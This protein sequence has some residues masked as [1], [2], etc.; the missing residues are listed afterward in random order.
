MK[1]RRKRK[2]RVEWGLLLISIGVMFLGACK[3]DF[4][5]KIQKHDPDDT[6]SV[7]LK[8]PKVLY[9]IVDGLRGQIIPQINPPTLTEMTQDAV[10]AYNG[11]SNNNHTDLSTWADM[12]TGVEPNKH[13]VRGADI[14]GN[15]LSDYPMFFKRLKE[16][17]PDYQ[18]AAFCSS[19][20]LSDDLIMDADTNESFS[21]NDTETK[22]A[23][24]KELGKENVTAILGEFHEVQQAGEDY[25]YDSSKKEYVDAIMEFDQEVDEIISMLKQRKN[26]KKENWLVIIA[27][28]EG[29]PATIPAED[30]DGTR[31]SDP[32]LNTFAIIYNPRFGSKFIPK[33]N[34]ANLPYE[35]YAV[36]LSGKGKSATDYGDAVN[37]YVPDV[38]QYNFGTSG[39][40]TVQI[41]VKVEDF[42]SSWP[43]FFGKRKSSYNRSENGWMFMFHGDNQWRVKV[44]G[45]KTTGIQNISADEWHTLTMKIYEENSKRLVAIYTDGDRLGSTVDI[46]GDDLSNDL[47]LTAGW[48]DGWTSTQSELYI[49]DIKMYDT[50]LADTYIDEHGGDI[51]LDENSPYYHNVIG[52]W[53]ATDGIGDKF[54]DQSPYHNDMIFNVTDNNEDDFVWDKFSVLSGL[55]HVPLPSNIINRVP[56]GVDMPLIIYKWMGLKINT[57]DLDGKFWLPKYD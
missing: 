54:K 31:F 20:N 17:N 9:L 8:E 2:V 6:V 36:E 30:Q 16:A 26:Y 22:E 15:D 24:I 27:S 32:K 12:L 37:A 5:T 19:D 55:I 3:E 47:P 18:T 45:N 38:D 41:K 21:G 29:G 43:S 53:P 48:S 42:G 52:Y 4:V 46:T 50:A 28:N 39:E 13:K 23:I 11:V 10:Y 35:G 56:R 33:P 14:A 44:G 57:F 7:Q 34:T 49:T 1:S 40:Y 25:G 51:G